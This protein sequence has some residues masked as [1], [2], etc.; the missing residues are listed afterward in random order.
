MERFTCPVCGKV[1]AGKDLPD[2]E[3]IQD[4][5]SELQST[6]ILKAFLEFDFTHD[7]PDL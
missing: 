1:L 7:T 3:S 2:P 5:F 4:D 6:R